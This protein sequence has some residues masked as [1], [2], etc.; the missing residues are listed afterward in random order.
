MSYFM[1][2]NGKKPDLTGLNPIRVMPAAEGQRYIPKCVKDFQ[3]L[4]LGG[5]FWF[6]DDGYTST[7]DEFVTDAIHETWSEGTLKHT[8]FY[9]VLERCERVGNSIFLWYGN[10]NSHLNLTRLT[11]FEEIVQLI[12][13][14]DKPFHQPTF[15]YLNPKAPGFGQN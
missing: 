1:V 6:I 9:Q 2:V 8:P 15:F 5:D 4:G 13:N 3:K 7:S 12:E 14:N 11:E 10:H